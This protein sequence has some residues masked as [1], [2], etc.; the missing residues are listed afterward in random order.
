MV[1]IGL[2][3]GFGII[4]SPVS[5]AA[6]TIIMTIAV[7]DCVHIVNAYLY[8]LR[9]GFEKDTAI[10]ESFKG[11]LKPIF[12]TSITTTIGFLSMNFSESPPFRDLGNIVAAGVV[13]AFLFS[14]T[15]LPILLS[16]IPLK[17]VP[18]KS[19]TN[20]FILGISEIVILNPIKIMAGCLLLSAPLLFLA[21]DNELDDNFVEYFD[22][23]I[24]FRRAS[25]YTM[26]NLT[27]LNLIEYSLSTNIENGIANPAY[28]EKVE[29]FSQWY[30]TQPEVLHVSSF[31][32]LMK[33]LNKNLHDNEPEFYRTPKDRA[34]AAQNLLLYELSL[35]YGL[36]LYNQISFDKSST[37]VTVLLNSISTIQLLTLERRAQSWFNANAP[38][39]QNAGASPTIMFGHIGEDNIRGM[40]KGTF[41]A[42]IIIT[43]MIAVMLRSTQ[44]GI[45]SLF[46]NIIPSVIAFGIWSLLVGKIGVAA[47]VVV[48]MT[49]G[50]VVDDTV[51]F[52]TKYLHA[53]REL[54]MD[55][56]DAI[57]YAYDS[58]GSALFITS[59]VLVAGF[60]ILSQS[61]FTANGDMGILTAITI[62]IALLVDLFLLPAVIIIVNR[63][64]T[65]NDSTKKDV[66]LLA[67]ST[68]KM[69]T[70]T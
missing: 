68:I 66:N 35:P 43:M 16:L 56:N 44:M 50:I 26:E 49:L 21:T 17:S 63:L 14:L 59:A 55:T 5:V 1:A 57:R 41:M 45:I 62:T 67:D 2:A 4:L 8:H 52:L 65:K 70:D 54:D 47:S 20:N 23:S 37:R 13:A 40:F 36:D 30:R 29:A 46:V 10:I 6:P 24:E 42:L 69:S 25:D 38:E 12:I 61:G 27:G 64:G 33:R 22:E 9:D 32:D 34:L 3:S 60:S 48:S 58:V 11:N 18:E 28:M 51:H 19:K 53:K 39:L 31:T 15:I 7:A